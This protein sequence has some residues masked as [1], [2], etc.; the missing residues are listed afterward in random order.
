MSRHFN[1]RKP[2]NPSTYVVQDKQKEIDVRRLFIENQMI[3]TG[4]GGVLPDHPDPTSLRRVL[5]IG[6]GSG[7]WVIEAALTYPTMSVFGIDI[8]QQMI[9]YARE[10]AQEQQISDRVELHVMD[11]LRMLEF[12]TGFFDL[13]NMR[14]GASFVRTWDWPKLLSEMLRV[15]SIGGTIQIT[16]GGMAEYHNS[17]ALQQYHEMIVCALFRS[18]H[19]FEQ[20]VGTFA[21][22]LVPLLERNGFQQV[23]M[24]K[25]K[26]EFHAGTTQGQ[27]YYEDNMYGLMAV[28]P[29]LQKYA[30]INTDYDSLQQ[31]AL[32]EMQQPDFYA[33]WEMITT[34]GIK[35]RAARA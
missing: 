24:C 1:P 4:L 12:P 25:R 8:S 32:K 21:D 26:L 28:G 7:G 30:C 19:L 33:T 13:V 10:Q 29:F 31:Q 20:K 2:E 9:D 15:T 18:G 35:R 22:H 5:D 23:R 17:P 27:L 6:C 14:F 11:A 16:E 3:N 34:S